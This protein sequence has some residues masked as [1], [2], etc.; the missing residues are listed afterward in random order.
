LLEPI[1]IERPRASIAWMREH[2]P[3]VLTEAEAMLA[4]RYPGAETRRSA[5]KAEQL[6]TWRVSPG[7]KGLSIGCVSCKYMAGP[8]AMVD[9][10]I[11]REGRLIA[12]PRLNM[13]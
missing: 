8:L 6:A 9:I 11:T 12:R 13:R 1:G 4:E 5:V 7:M 3:P 2:A 10:M